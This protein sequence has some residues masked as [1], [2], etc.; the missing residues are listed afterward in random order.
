MIYFSA[1]LVLG[2]LY[3]AFHTFRALRLSKNNRTLE[4][5]VLRVAVS[6]TNERGPIVAEQIYSALHG[7]ETNYSAVDYLLGRPKPRISLEIAAVNNVIQFFIWAPR[8]FRN[9]IEGQIYAQ[10]PD[11]EIQE[12][13]DYA[14]EAFEVYEVAPPPVA[15]TSST[16]LVTYES[17]ANA[18]E[19][20]PH[21]AAMRSA[22]TAELT[23]KEA[24]RN[25]S[26]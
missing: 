12:V 9:V 26:F 18:I 1:L 21:A 10:Y 24:L 16:G 11:V 19:S 17:N 7:L 5:V 14:K 20:R 4:S 13:E 25:K 15:T 2:F 22:V 6:K 23:L 3:L 8:R